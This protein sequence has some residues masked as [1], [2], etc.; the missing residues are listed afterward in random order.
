[1][2][3]PVLWRLDFTGFTVGKLCGS[4]TGMRSVCTESPAMPLQQNTLALS[5]LI[6]L[7]S[8]ST[9]QYHS[10]Q[11]KPK[12]TFLICILLCT[13]GFLCMFLWIFTR[14]PVDHF[15]C[16]RSV[17]MHVPVNSGTHC[18]GSLRKFLCVIKQFLLNLTHVPVNLYI[19]S[20]VYFIRVLWILAQFTVDLYTHSCSSLHSA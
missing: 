13:C 4:A 5:L 7:L 1:V 10:P 3:L 8:Q 14:V 11:E 17:L 2:K 18:S 20:S 15:I 9:S 16:S 6:D 19:Y 12:H